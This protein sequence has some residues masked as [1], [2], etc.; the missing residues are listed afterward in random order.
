ML[1]RDVGMLCL[2]VVLARHRAAVPSVTWVGKAATFVL[3]S[4]LPILVVAGA[5]PS[6]SPVLTPIGIVVA[7]VGAVL[8]WVAGTGY[9]LA[10]RRTII[11]GR[12]D[13]PEPS[14]TLIRQRRSP[15]GR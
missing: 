8:Y 5:F 9:A 15:D 10:A 6:T 4:A 7:V 12:N 14:A 2:G 3:L 1:A 13:T 11:G